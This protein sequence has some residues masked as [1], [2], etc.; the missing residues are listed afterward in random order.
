MESAGE[1]L[2]NDYYSTPWRLVCKDCGLTFGEFYGPATIASCRCGSNNW[3]YETG[4][5]KIEWPEK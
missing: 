1:F 2:F 3:T 5:V 4:K